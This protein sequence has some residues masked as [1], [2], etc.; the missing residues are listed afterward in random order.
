MATEILGKV[1]LLEIDVANGTSYK[2]LVC[3]EDFELSMSSSVETT[4]TQCG[5]FNVPGTPGAQVTFNAVTNALPEATEI[6]YEDL[7]TV[8]NNVT[9]IA[10]RIQNA[11]QTS[12]SAGGA[13]YHAFSGYVTNLSLPVASNGVVKFSG[14]IQST[15]SIDL[16]A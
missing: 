2:T 1:T 9:K 15:G 4:E 10:V 5:Q 11:A 12:V 16:T 8:L 6:S 7:A 13:F 14:T 3:I